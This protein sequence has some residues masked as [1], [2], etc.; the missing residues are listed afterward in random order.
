MFHIIL[1]IDNTLLE[2]RVLP[3]IGQRAEHVVVLS[4][5]FDEFHL[6]G[7]EKMDILYFYLRPRAKEFIEWAYRNRHIVASLSFFSA[8]ASEYVKTVVDTLIPKHR[9]DDKFPY[10]VLSRTDCEPH[11]VTA[12]V[13]IKNLNRKFWEVNDIGATKDNTLIV[14]DNSDT[15][16]LNPINLVHCPKWTPQTDPYRNCT[17]FRGF[18]DTLHRMYLM[19]RKWEQMRK[20]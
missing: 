1:D 4:R 5:N 7:Y 9:R 3:M 16:Y 12:G 6:D 11:P 19:K 13:L 20:K 14:D 2:S 8:G 17:F 10:K 15:A 18:I